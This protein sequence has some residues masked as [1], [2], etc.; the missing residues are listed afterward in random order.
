MPVGLK[1]FHSSGFFAGIGATYVH[2][3]VERD[4]AVLAA[5]PTVAGSEDFITVDAALGWRLPNRVG[6]VSLEA[7][8]LL[9]E[10]FNFVPFV[11]VKYSDRLLEVYVKAH[12]HV[13][14][15]RSALELGGSDGK[16]I[17]VRTTYVLPDGKTVED[18]D[19]PSGGA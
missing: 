14:R 10:D 13:Y 3:E 1:Y 12:R 17:E 4:P 16:P 7:R 19:G 9:D 2:Q 6:I 5:F 15:D 18:Y 11:E 8:N